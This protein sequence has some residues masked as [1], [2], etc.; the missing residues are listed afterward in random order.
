MDVPQNTSA[1]A[2]AQYVGGKCIRRSRG[3]AWRELQVS[4]IE[5]PQTVDV[6]PLPAV[7]ETFLAW[8]ISGEAEFQEREKGRPWVSNRIKKG[9]FFLTTGGA[10]Y[11]CR[12]EART[13][14]PFVTMAVFLALPLLQRAMVEVFGSQAA[15]AKLRDVSAFVDPVLDLLMGQIHGEL[16][17]KKA[18]PLG[19]Q[20]LG[21]LVA[22]HLARNYA[23]LEEGSTSPS[24]LLPG[25]KLNQITEWMTAHSSEDFGLAQ[26]AA[27]AGISK[28]HFHRLFSRATGVSPARYH[29]NLRMESARRLLRETDKGVLDIALEVGYA[30][31]SHFSKLFRRENGSSPGE[32]RRQR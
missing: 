19:L 29:T 21:S 6:L 31:P 14:E 28:F 17:R 30:N 1:E 22:I 27:L 25:Y 12:W 16:M 15:N 7:S 3:K 24:T 11:E 13:P 2:F 32:Y 5:V 9:S 20:G 8:T 18:S 4:I 26:L 23:S 10:P